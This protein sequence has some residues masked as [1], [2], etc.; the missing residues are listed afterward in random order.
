M[1][2]S[3]T[4]NADPALFNLF[5]REV[6]WYGLCWAI[7]LLIAVVIVERIYKREKIADQWFN[8]LFIYIV[9]GI[10]IG[11]RLGHC[12]FYEWH[13]GTNDYL[14][15]PLRI[16]KVW[17]GGLASHGGVLG[18]IVGAWLYCRQTGQN[19]L[20]VLDRLVVACGITA[21]FIRLGNLMNSEIYG[22]PTS[23][24]WGFEFPLFNKAGDI[25]AH[26]PASHPTQIYEALVYLFVF[27]LLMY[28]YWRTSAAKKE[29]MLLGVAMI[30]IFGSRFF[31]E[32]LKNVQENFENTWR[33]TIGID[34][35]QAL[36]IPFVIWGIWLVVRASRKT[37]PVQQAIVEKSSNIKTG[38]TGK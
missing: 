12:L 8:K 4:W 36:S 33:E 18:V 20:W 14:T 32:Y 28:L 13:D 7:G 2:L 15:H 10:I 24:P 16:L 9:L 6:R 17:E 1:I 34:M 22:S 27:G 26:T 21:A 25:V 29:G 19:M 31:L 37:Y 23:L 30:I 3:I 11:A 35:G 38:K 5:G